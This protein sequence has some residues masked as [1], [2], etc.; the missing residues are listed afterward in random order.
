MAR[1]TSPVFNLIRGSING[2]T[3][4][5]N[6]YHQIVCRGRTAPVQPNTQIQELLRS[7]FAAAAGAWKALTDAQRLEWNQYA[8][9][10]VYAGPL[11][12]YFVTGR[13]LMMGATSLV[14]F[15]R[16]KYQPTLVVVN[17]VP[18][19]SG[20]YQL[21]NV[22]PVALIAAG[23][24]FRVTLSNTYG[25]SIAV[26]VEVSRPFDASRERFKG[27][28]DTSKTQ[29]L[30]MSSPLTSYAVFSTLTA[31]YRYFFRVRAVTASAVGIPAIQTVLWEGSYIAAV[32]P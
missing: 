19:G 20:R 17:T 12:N 31:G 29:T 7:S 8:Q 2:A 15:I 26:M 23:T 18:P 4:L 11:G 1:M 3:Y 14:R 28:Y 21:N 22:V 16:D 10:V 25:K 5:S 9:T 6:Q 27:P 13:N 32:F 24:G 30:I